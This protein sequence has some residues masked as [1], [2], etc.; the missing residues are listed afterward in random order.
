M[1]CL[2]FRRTARPYPAA[3]GGETRGGWAAKDAGAL[4]WQCTVS[5]RLTM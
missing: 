3:R 5:S 1:R 2:E 4:A